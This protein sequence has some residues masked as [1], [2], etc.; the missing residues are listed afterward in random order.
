MVD[1]IKLNQTSLIVSV[2][3]KIFLVNYTEQLSLSA[4][5]IHAEHQVTFG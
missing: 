2:D 4:H 3:G 1:L 5:R